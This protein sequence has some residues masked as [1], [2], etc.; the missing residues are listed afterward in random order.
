MNYFKNYK[1]TDKETSKHY[2]IILLIILIGM[3]EI[4]SLISISIFLTLLVSF[5]IILSKLKL[6]LNIESIFKI[7]KYY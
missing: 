4:S 6:F 5:E 7:K 1:I 3:Y 2:F